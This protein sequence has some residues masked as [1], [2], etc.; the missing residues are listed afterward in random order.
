MSNYFDSA[1]GGVPDPYGGNQGGS[2]GDTDWF[3]RIS[4]LIGQGVETIG[5]LVVQVAGPGPSEGTVTDSNGQVH[6]VV[7]DEGGNPSIVSQIP[8][9]GWF[10]GAALIYLLVKR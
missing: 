6:V 9:W 1:T 2:G 8:P 4:G 3:G 5:G 7:V 10:A